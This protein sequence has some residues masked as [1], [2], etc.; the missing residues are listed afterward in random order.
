MAAMPSS[1]SARRNESPCGP[2]IRFVGDL[3]EDP[4]ELAHLAENRQSPAADN[5]GGPID[6]V[7]RDEFLSYTAH[8]LRSPL[9]IVLGYAQAIA[10]RLRD[11]PEA[12]RDLA[13]LEHVIGAARRLAGM[14]D[15][16]LDVSRIETG[17]LKLSIR[18]FSLVPLA[19]D[20]V[21][22]FSPDR[23][24]RLECDP[25]LPEALADR[26]RIESVL[27]ILVGNALRVTPQNLA[28]IVTIRA[29]HGDL[30]VAVEDRGPT[31]HADLLPSIFGLARPYPSSV[32]RREG[33]G[34]GL[35]VAEGTVRA[36][37]G[38]I[39]VECPYPAE[40]FGNRF[41]FTI[42]RADSAPAD[43]TTT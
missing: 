6:Q 9:T 8:E 30:E 11:R 28:V 41:V 22:Q 7:K 13:E 39:R 34:F 31:I 2:E 1:S 36:L 32:D 29:P 26:A 27:R 19:Q 43:A 4:F 38:E 12:A 25:D 24:I 20:L 35:F 42:S 33:L 10:R 16:M 5:P 40:P 21:L 17:R 23:E 14:I 15:E 3:F 37:G 18:P